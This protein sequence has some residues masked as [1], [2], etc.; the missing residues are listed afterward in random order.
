MLDFKILQYYSTMIQEIL[1]LDLNGS[2]KRKILLGRS[3]AFCHGVYG[4][5]NCK[6]SYYSMTAVTM[7][8]D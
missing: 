6:D 4:H 8:N 7:F 5:L 1:I 2:R 3:S